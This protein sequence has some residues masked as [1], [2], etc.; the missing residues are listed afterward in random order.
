[1]TDRVFNDPERRPGGGMT[2]S[3]Q[4]PYATN[5]YAWAMSCV[6]PFVGEQVLDIGG[7]YGAHLEFIL[8]HCTHLTT[9][10]MSPEHVEGLRHRFSDHRS[11]E[12]RR[13]DFGRD[14]LDALLAGR[15]FDTITCFN[16]LEHIQDDLAALKD[17]HA[18]LAGR[19][20]N[21]CLQ[22]PAL[23]WLYGTLDYAAGHFRRYN[24]PHLRQLLED[25]G[26]EVIRLH[27]FNF[28]G[29][30]PWFINVHIL[31]RDIDSDSV[32]T[33]IKVFDRIFVPALRWIE[34]RITPPIGQ[35]LIA[36]AKAARS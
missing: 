18:I 4:M 10:D 26:F 11:F 25:A 21:L 28:F 12:A 20:G 3:S 6:V 35:S 14:D 24:A 19:Q 33:Q 2:M 8:P 9:V 22:V 27:Y 7:G 5:Y 1:M 13:F 30:L 29:V 15:H 32:N 23:R 34:A 17:F 16:V 36:V 31:K